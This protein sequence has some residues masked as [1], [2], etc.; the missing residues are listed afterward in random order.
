[1]ESARLETSENTILD[2]TSNETSSAPLTA[3]TGTETEWVEPVTPD[4]VVARE[5]QLAPI[6]PVTEAENT[7]ASS[8]TGPSKKHDWL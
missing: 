2:T 1:M 7:G 6:E 8:S 5:S 4:D 3:G